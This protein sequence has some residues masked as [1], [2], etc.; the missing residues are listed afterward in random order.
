M[1]TLVSRLDN[2]FCFLFEHLDDREPSQK[3][4]RHIPNSRWKTRWI[5]CVA[6]LRLLG[7]CLELS[8]WVRC[9]ETTLGFSVEGNNIHELELVYKV[10][11]SRPF[12]LSSPSFSNFENSTRNLDIQE[13]DYNP[14]K[15][16]L[17]DAR[18]HHLLAEELKPYRRVSVHNL[19][20]PFPLSWL[21]C[22]V[23]KA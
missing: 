22:F 20:S 12:P 14:S 18:I 2:E 11:W 6:I 15:K 10:N 16:D 9:L 4:S 13:L 17:T 21:K 5:S 3:F 8:R 19:N 7:K 1:T 23:D